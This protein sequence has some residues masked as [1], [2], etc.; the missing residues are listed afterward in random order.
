MAGQILFVSGSDT[1]VGKTVV[2]ALLTRQLRAAGA[3]VAAVKPICS[4]GRSD[5]RRLQQAAA[6]VL[7][8][9]AVNPWHFRATLAPVLAARREHRRVLLR[10]VVRH[11]AAIR[12]AFDFVV[13]EGAGGLLSPL[14]AD[15]DSR[16]LILALQ[17]RAI[18]VIPNQLGAVG[19]ARLVLAALPA[20]AAAQAHVVLSAPARPDAAARTNARLLAEFLP[21]RRLHLL[22]WLANPFAAQLPPALRRLAARLRAP[23]T[24]RPEP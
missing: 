16:D 17:A 12:R 5:A 19:Q 22:P 24:D 23:Q 2:A 10:Q 7:P 1:G 15:F 3:R 11:L 20:K 18:L 6:A 14:G 21:A 13:V 4:G 8:L 9:D